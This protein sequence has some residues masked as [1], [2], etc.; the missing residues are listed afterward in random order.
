[1]TLDGYCDHTAINPDEEIHQHY[2]NLLNNSDTIL[3]GRI[4]FGLMGYW[5][6]FIKTPSG[7]PAMDD[8]GNAIDRIEKIVFSHTLKAIDWDSAA[9][10]RRP[11]EEEVLDLR[12]QS[13]ADILVG[14]RSIIIQLLKL[15]LIAEFQLCIHPVVVGSGLPLFNEIGDRTT[16]ELI[17][18]KR[19]PSGAIILYYKP[20]LQANT[21]S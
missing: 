12:Q 1:M 11:L 18:T 5:Q 10:A 13:G 15:N 16:L 20:Q 3:Y 4:T 9:L 6:T 19:F 21:F 17:E 7:E 8:F 2:T 14:S